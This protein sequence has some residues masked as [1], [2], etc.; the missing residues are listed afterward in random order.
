MSSYTDREEIS[1]YD[2]TLTATDRGTPGRQSSSVTLRVI[3]ID[4]NDNS[5]VFSDKVGC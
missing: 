3:V 4:A 2:L 5:P 1:T